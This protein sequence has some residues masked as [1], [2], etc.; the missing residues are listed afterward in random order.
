MATTKKR[1]DIDNLL[2]ELCGIN[3]DMDIIKYVNQKYAD[4]D[5]H[6]YD[7]EKTIMNAISELE[8]VIEKQRSKLLAIIASIAIQ[9]SNKLT[10]EQLKRI[11]EIGLLT[12]FGE[13]SQRLT[14][15]C[16][17]PEN[18]GKLMKWAGI[19]LKKEPPFSNLYIRSF[20]DKPIELIMTILNQLKGL[21]KNKIRKSISY[22]LKENKNLYHLTGEIELDIEDTEIKKISLKSEFQFDKDDIS[23]FEEHI[24]LGRYDIEENYKKIDKRLNF[25]GVNFSELIVELQT[26]L[27][28]KV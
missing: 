21:K 22:K 12:S 3:M 23:E 4:Y 15:D 24:Y 25:Y 8:S 19:N 10:K 14:L 2:N 6:S 5:I 28:E 17:T 11:K 1:L 9:S 13:M 20:K 7:G 16:V 18:Y 27:I 26:E